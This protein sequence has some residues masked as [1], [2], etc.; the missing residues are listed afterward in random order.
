MTEDGLGIHLAQSAPIPRD[1]DEHIAELRRIYHAA[2]AARGPKR[3][4][5]D[6]V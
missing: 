1:I 2:I 5:L 6:A 4:S 3:P